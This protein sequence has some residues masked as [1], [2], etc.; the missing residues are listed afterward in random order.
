[1]SKL[2]DSVWMAGLLRRSAFVIPALLCL[3]NCGCGLLHIPYSTTIP[4][5]PLRRISV[6]A[7]DTREPLRDAKVSVLLYKHDNWLKPRGCWGASESSDDVREAVGIITDEGCE[8]WQA[9]NLGDGTFKIAPRTKCSWL[10]VWL[11]LPPVLGPFLYYTY[12]GVVIASALGHKTIWLTD[13]VAL[14]CRPSQKSVDLGSP[15]PEGEYVEQVDGMLR[16]YLPLAEDQRD[17]VG[18]MLHHREK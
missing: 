9:E 4:R 17:S 15:L 12:D 8:T 3:L 11:P 5:E 14:P 16:V 7:Y 10:M 6:R 13:R 1:M 18:A 2:T